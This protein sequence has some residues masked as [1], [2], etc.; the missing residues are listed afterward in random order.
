VVASPTFE[1]T[2]LRPP[3]RRLCVIWPTSRPSP[4]ELLCGRLADFSPG[5]PD[6]LKEREAGFSWNEIAAAMAD[7][8]IG[9]RISPKSLRRACDTPGKAPK[10]AASRGA[11]APNRA[12][13]KPA[14][15]DDDE[16][17]KV[18]LNPIT[19]RPKIVP[20]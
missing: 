11:A 8:A 7:P 6:V 14:A 17:T 15:P 2:S 13:P 16:N 12:T 1:P 18:I 9:I 5:R 4:H 20:M 3:A 19:G 10:T